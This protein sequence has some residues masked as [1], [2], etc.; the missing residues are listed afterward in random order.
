MM[1]AKLFWGSTNCGGGGDTSSRA[2][3]VS[4]NDP[5]GDA[6]DEVGRGREGGALNTGNCRLL[7]QRFL[8]LAFGGGNVVSL[9]A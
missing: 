8:A 9:R 6:D 1:E 3:A 7:I 5:I 2:S 4:S